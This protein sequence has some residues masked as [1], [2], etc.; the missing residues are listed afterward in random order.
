[1]ASII[2]LCVP[3]PFESMAFIGRIVQ[4]GQIPTIPIPLFVFAAINSER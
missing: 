2:F 4:S 1:M 3:I